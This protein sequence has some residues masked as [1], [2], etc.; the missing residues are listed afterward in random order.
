MAARFIFYPPHQVW[1]LALAALIGMGISR[2]FSKILP[3]HLSAAF[4]IVYVFLNPIAG[5]F[6][7][8]WWIYTGWSLLGLLAL[9]AFLPLTASLISGDSYKEN[10]MIF[11]VVMYHPILTVITGVIRL[12]FF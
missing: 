7:P 11:L 1:I 5:I 4:F 10:A 12:M 6:A 9:L 2:I 3:W 8:R